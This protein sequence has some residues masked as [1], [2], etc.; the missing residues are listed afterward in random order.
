MPLERRE[1]AV[2]NFGWRAHH[3]RWGEKKLVDIVVVGG[4]ESRDHAGPVGDV[5][6]AKPDDERPPAV[7]AAVADEPPRDL[8]RPFPRGVG[9]LQE[10]DER[11]QRVD[12]R[13]AEPIGGRG[14]GLEGVAA[15]ILDRLGE[16]LRITAPQGR[17]IADRLHDRRHLGHAGTER[18]LEPKERPLIGF[19]AE[20][21]QQR[22]PAVA[23]IR[24]C[25]HELVE[26]PERRRE[27]LDV[28]GLHRGVE[29][30]PRRGLRRP[31]ERVDDG[32]RQRIEP[33]GCDGWGRGFGGPDGRRQPDH[34]DD[35]EKTPR[36]AK[37]RCHT[38]S[39]SATRAGAVEPKLTIRSTAR[40]APSAPRNVT[41][42]P[43]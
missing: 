25:L 24:D 40:E 2:T 21:G 27:R 32:L 14:A 10:I 29:Q 3:E 13:A 7:G 26:I 1:G 18:S 37:R 36:Y 39:W 35:A 22:C 8:P 6:R 9:R 38:A 17:C 16:F 11:R 33:F 41:S 23:R 5:G 19:V 15:Q 4:V 20:I 43:A 34:Q 30:L 31:G 42:Q 12:S 28:V